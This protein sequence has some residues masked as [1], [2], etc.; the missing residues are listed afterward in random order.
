MSL[1]SSSNLPQPGTASRG[2]QPYSHEERLERAKDIA[3]QFARHFGP[4]HRATAIYGSLARAADGPYSDIEMFVVVGGEKVDRCYEW[5]S[6]PW[7]AEVDVC[8]LDVLMDQAAELE[9]FWP[10]T[11]GAFVH[12]LVLHDP[13]GIFERARQAALDHT[14]DEFTAAIAETI[15]GDLYEVVGKVRNALSG[16]RTEM[17][18]AFTLDAVRYGACL[19]GLNQRRVY[20]SGSTV[21]VESLA[22][23]NRPDGYDALLR[24]VMSGD[25]SRPAEVGAALDLF[26]VGVEAWAQRLGIPLCHDLGDLLQA[27]LE[28]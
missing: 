18:T 22:L 12:Q 17:V 19:I 26:W 7:K 25:L 24:M 9:D 2:P 10:V 8:S 1:P 15:V 11:H 20:T 28:D 23:P 16:G 14:E 27:S 3:G 5:S 6:G 13:E 21:F 4:Q